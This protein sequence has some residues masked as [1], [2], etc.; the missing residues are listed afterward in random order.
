[1]SPPGSGTQETFLLNLG[2][3]SFKPLPY[4][5]LYTGFLHFCWALAPFSFRS[6]LASAGLPATGCQRGATRSRLPKAD[7][8]AKGLGA[9]LTAAWRSRSSA[10]MKRQHTPFDLTQGKSFLSQRPKCTSCA[11]VLYKA[12][13]SDTPPQR[14]VF[15]IALTKVESSQAD[16][17]GMQCIQH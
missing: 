7:P 14:I 13:Q 6:Y 3:N 5:P 15:D 16:T 1:M 8:P 4:A 2:L 10:T 11:T 17:A 9:G 12:S